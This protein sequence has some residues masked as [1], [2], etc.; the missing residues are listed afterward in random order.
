MPSKNNVKHSICNVLL[1]LK[2]MQDLLTESSSKFLSKTLSDLVGVD[3]IPFIMYTNGD[4]FKRMG[5][6]KTNNDETFIT[7][8]FRIESIDQ[9]NSRTHVSLLR[10]LNIHGEDTQL[11]SDL[12]MLKKT[13]ASTD[14]DLSQIN[15]IQP[16][17]IDYLK[18]K[19]IIEPK[20]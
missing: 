17:D 18:R 19:I 3:T 1:D 15:G 2:N 5:R 4:L 9:E 7:S 13:A 6:D 12:I 20:W 8:Y 11:M 10:P 16:L 14:I